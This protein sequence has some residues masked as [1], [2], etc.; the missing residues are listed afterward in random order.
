MADPFRLAPFDLPFPP[1][2]RRLASHAP[3]AAV[4][5]T[6]YGDGQAL[7]ARQF[8]VAERGE[9]ALGAGVRHGAGQ[10]VENPGFR[11]IDASDA[12]E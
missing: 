2:N 3:D 8:P 10:S 6:Q 5:G 7:A 12:L 11:L 9:T 4:W 1:T